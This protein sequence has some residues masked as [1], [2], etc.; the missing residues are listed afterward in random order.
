MFFLTIPHISEHIPEDLLPRMNSAANLRAMAE[1]CLDL[2]FA[3][4]GIETVSGSVHLAVVNLNRSR[5]DKNP[6]TGKPYP[7]ALSQHVLKD[8]HGTPLFRPGAEPSALE[9]LRFL[10]RYYDPFFSRV[11]HLVQSGRFSF[12]ADV[13]SM[14][15]HSTSYASKADTLGE[16]PD[17]CLSNNGD[18]A[19]ETHAD[20]MPL[21]CPT[22]FIKRLRKMLAERGYHCLLNDPF[23][24]G[25]IIQTYGSHIPCVQVELSKRLFMTADD[26]VCSAERLQVLAGHL[27]DAFS[28]VDGEMT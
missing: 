9:R 27:S 1:P 20:G 17:I 13:H 19:G 24:G 8:F 15:D 26:G 4:S 2:L 21:T 25:T 11:E 12:F 22:S 18:A 23:R 6:R 5:N 3:P 16:R 10:E 28:A 14:N 7:E